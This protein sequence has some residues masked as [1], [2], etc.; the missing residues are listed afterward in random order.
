MDNAT[1]R[2]LYSVNCAPVISHASNTEDARLYVV[3]E[4]GRVA[5]L[6]PMP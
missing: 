1:G 6:E 3:D 4:Y 2:K 5:C